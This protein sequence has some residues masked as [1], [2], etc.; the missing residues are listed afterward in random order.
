MLGLQTGNASSYVRELGTDAQ[1]S[2]DLLL[3]RRVVV[4]VSF[5]R[6]GFGLRLAQLDGE[7]LNLTAQAMNEF[8]VRV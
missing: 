5:E 7:L 1:L 2:L 3:C 6:N 4:D 8:A